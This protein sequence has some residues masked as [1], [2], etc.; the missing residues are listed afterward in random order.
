MKH[1]PLLLYSL[2]IL[3]QQCAPSPLPATSEEVGS[4]DPRN[5]DDRSVASQ[6]TH[7]TFPDLALPETSDQH[8][9]EGTEAHHRNRKREAVPDPQMRRETYKERIIKAREEAVRARNQQQ[10]STFQER[11]RAN[12]KTPQQS[13]TFPE[14]ESGIQTTPQQDPTFQQSAR[15]IQTTP[16]QDPNFQQSARGR[17]TTPQQ[18]PTFQQSARGRQTTP[19]Q[20]PNFRQSARGRP[21]TREELDR[22]RRL[23][24]LEQTNLKNKKNGLP[25]VQDKSFASNPEDSYYDSGDIGYATQP[26]NLDWKD[27]QGYWNGLNIHQIKSW[28]EQT[29]YDT[30]ELTSHGKA[31]QFL[32]QVKKAKKQ[33]KTSQGSDNDNEDEEAS[34]D[35]EEGEENKSAGVQESG[36]DFQALK[37]SGQQIRQGTDN[38]PQQRRPRR[39]ID[40]FKLKGNREPT[41][42]ERFTEGNKDYE[43]IGKA[44]DSENSAADYHR[45][46]KREAVPDPQ[47]QSRKEQFAKQH[48]VQIS[49]A[50]T[51]TQE[52]PKS[53][54]QLRQERADLIEKYN[55]Y[56]ARRKEKLR[57][58]IIEKHN[59]FQAIVKEYEKE[60]KQKDYLDEKYA[61][62]NGQ[63]K[64]GTITEGMEETPS[65]MSSVNI[66]LQR[67]DDVQND[68][69]SHNKQQFSFQAEKQFAKKILQDDDYGGEP[70]G[71]R[72][73]LPVRQ[74]QTGGGSEKGAKR[75]RMRKREAMQNQ[76]T[77]KSRPQGRVIEMTIKNGIVTDIKDGDRGRLPAQPNPLAQDSKNEDQGD[78]NDREEKPGP[79]LEDVQHEAMELEDQFG[80]EWDK[81][82]DENLHRG[83]WRGI[84]AAQWS[85]E[86]IELTKQ[87]KEKFNKLGDYFPP[88][89]QAPNFIY[90]PDFD[91]QRGK[92]KSG[93]E[94][95]YK[96]LDQLSET[97]PPV[98]TAENFVPAGQWYRTTGPEG[99]S[100]WAKFDV[101]G[102]WKFQGPQGRRKD[103]AFFEENGK[104][105][106]RIEPDTHYPYG[107]NHTPKESQ[108]SQEREYHR[109]PQN[110]YDNTVNDSGTE[111]AGWNTQA[112]QHHS[113]SNTGRGHEAEPDVQFGD[114]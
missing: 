43:Y 103:R 91:G 100:G 89:R 92:W 56:Q 20:D 46:R 79:S 16:Q 17:Q 73:A 2:G 9:S 25:P 32:R 68:S 86:S 7:K 65:E 12:V 96:P 4:N 30:L 57:K 83:N 51:V 52:Q 108:Y 34:D 22:G 98:K 78:V 110:K 58:A 37:S 24:L 112:Q 29:I 84:K 48:N 74:D 53:E 44:D 19:Q 55:R 28:E 81:L 49:G 40:S 60:K 104:T 75:L 26:A 111:D 27:P 50:D 38:V 95:S 5:G 61:Y 93:Y 33:Y 23:V 72:D 39:T 64:L 114:Q 10:D 70:K 63:G 113:Y 109:N 102:Q 69:D 77:A 15:G 14:L 107:K 13:F 67:S 6:F 18:N 1:K 82:R 97:N 105:Y 85:R 76:Q 35:G 54:E 106:E 21:R 8:S 41:V 45:N 3:L 87:F 59:R 66:D 88:G 101:D 42:G 62:R 71:D 11:P 47:M 80:E 31:T 36:R 90:V 99:D 94:G